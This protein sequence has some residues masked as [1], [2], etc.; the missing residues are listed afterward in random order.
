MT[1]KKLVKG[2]QSMHP[3]VPLIS[4]VIVQI[5]AIART[6]MDQFAAFVA[7]PRTVVKSSVYNIP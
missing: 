3:K 1:P 5:F 2:C 7:T 4:K 6:F